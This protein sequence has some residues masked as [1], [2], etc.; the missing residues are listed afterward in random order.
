MAYNYEKFKALVHYICHMA[1][2]DELGAVKLNKIL[3]FSDMVTYINRG[4]SMTGSVYIKRQFGS[5]PKDI[6]QALDELS[7]GE[8]MI[9]R[10]VPFFGNT[11][12]E[13][14]SL[15]E[16][17]IDRFDASEISLV[18]NIMHH[19]C[20]HHTAGSISDATHD[21][22]WGLA[23]MGEEIPYCAIYGAQLG[24]I[25]EEDIQWGKESIANN[26][27]AYGEAA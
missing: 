7:A 3:W 14:I 10:D 4:K 27:A 13:Y 8:K 26:V 24:E 19:I 22:I 18:A 20:H 6:L 9:I 2:H 5:V 15:A 1:D 25:T 11:K 16:P 12:R 23:G 21:I 17:D